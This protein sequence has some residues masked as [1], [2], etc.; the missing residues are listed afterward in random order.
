MKAAP[1]AAGESTASSEEAMRSTSLFCGCQTTTPTAVFHVLS[2]EDA[3]MKTEAKLSEMLNTSLNAF[4][5]PVVGLCAEAH[6]AYGYPCNTIV[7]V[8]L[9]LHVLSGGG[10]FGGKHCTPVSTANDANST[11]C[12][13]PMVAACSAPKNYR[14]YIVVSFCV[15]SRNEAETDA[16]GGHAL[17][18]PLPRALRAKTKLI[19]TLYHFSACS[20]L[21]VREGPALP[22]KHETSDFLFRKVLMSGPTL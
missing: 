20:A 19:R 7:T 11:C 15:S 3:C 1:F 2:Y 8:N 6:V 17:P 14:I 9:A 12:Q 22:R 4:M 5:K 10:G 21:G 18:R 16:G 13:R